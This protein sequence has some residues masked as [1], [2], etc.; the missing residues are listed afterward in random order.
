MATSDYNERMIRAFEHGVDEFRGGW[1]EPSTKA[2]TIDSGI[3]EAYLKGFA[4]NRD[5]EHS[6]QLVQLELFVDTCGN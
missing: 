1:T 3:R 6:S 5:H 4:W 2:Y